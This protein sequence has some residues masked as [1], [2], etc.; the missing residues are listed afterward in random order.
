MAEPELRGAPAG[1]QHPL[2]RLVAVVAQLREHCPWM[3]QLTHSS[4]VEYL[5]EE[6]YEL[7]D[8]LDELPGTPAA[9]APDADTEAP[10][11]NTATTELRG[12]LG[13]VLLQVVLHA[14]LQ[15]EQGHFGLD[16]VVTSLTDKMIRRNPHVFA[17]DGSLRASFPATT[18][19]I[20][21]TWHRVKRAEEPRRED[22]FHG[23]PR[24]LPALALA[25]K[26]LRRIPV[27]L[28]EPIAPLPGAA[29]RTETELGDLLLAV[30]QQSTAVGLDPELALR[31]AV[32][33]LQARSRTLQ[34]EDMIGVS[35][36]VSTR[37]E[38][39]PSLTPP[40]GQVNP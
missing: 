36:D 7:V 27:G 31:S 19:S 10:A 21:E 4:L 38:P 30:V 9:D 26:T 37:L 2:D 32:L 34:A 18:D 40:P 15:R 1:T 23:I 25:A 33:R 14:Q 13:D 20:V 29:P 28:P 16:E 11:G 35:A 17:A 6:C 5:V 3:A 22:P 8:A 39:T 12:E 24:Q